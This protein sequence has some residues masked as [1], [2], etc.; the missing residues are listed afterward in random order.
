[1]SRTAFY[2]KHVAGRKFEA[3]MTGGG[4]YLEMYRSRTDRSWV[5]LGNAAVAM[6]GGVPPLWICEGGPE[7]PRFNLARF[8]A[9]EVI[10][11]AETFGMRIPGAEGRFGFFESAAWEGLKEVVARHPRRAAEAARGAGPE[12]W[13]E[14]AREEISAS[15]PMS[16]KP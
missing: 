12:S 6:Q 1:M 14:R 5:T 11:L 7:H 3:V 2:T 4:L 9:D 15:P 8:T 16:G 13:L 10:E